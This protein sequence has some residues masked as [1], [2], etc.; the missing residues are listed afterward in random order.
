MKK[1]Y[2]QPEVHVTDIQS[3]VVMQVASPVGNSLGIHN[4]EG[5]Q[6]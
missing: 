4:V 5:D 2:N 6:W 1:T 3:M